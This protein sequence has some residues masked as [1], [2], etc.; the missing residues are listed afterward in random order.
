MESNADCDPYIFWSG[1]WTQVGFVWIV[2]R[3]K[4]TDTKMGVVFSMRNTNGSSQPAVALFV[5][6]LLEGIFI[7][8]TSWQKASEDA[9]QRN[10]AG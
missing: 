8:R 4:Y 3:C 5:Q 1:V 10:A 2:V 7:T 6:S 9:A